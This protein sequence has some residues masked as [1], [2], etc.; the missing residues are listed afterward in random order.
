MV[1]G[2]PR[3]VS[4]VVEGASSGGVSAGSVSVMAPGVSHAGSAEWDGESLIGRSAS[5]RIPFDK[6]LRKGTAPYFGF[7]EV[8]AGEN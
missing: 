7:Y 4:A 2:G 6:V 1:Q 8:D 3:R 5:P